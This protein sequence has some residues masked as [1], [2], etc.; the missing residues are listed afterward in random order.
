MFSRPFIL[1]S[2]VDGLISHPASSRQIPLVPAWLSAS[3][4]WC[5][6]DDSYFD[7]GEIEFL[8]SFLVALLWWLKRLNIFFHIVT[9]EL[10]FIW[11]IYLSIFGHLLI[12]LFVLWP[13]IVFFKK[14]FSS[15]CVHMRVYVHTC[16][17]TGAT[18]CLGRPEDSLLELVLFF[19]LTG[20]RDQ[21]QLSLAESVFTRWAILL[22][23]CFSFERVCLI[24]YI[25]SEHNDMK[26]EL[27]SR[28]TTEII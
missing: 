10:Y 20:P 8:F 9:G 12:E 21:S 1:I 19:Y 7:W 16:M 3:L 4:G 28:R 24:S 18:V 6:L 22:A 14:I 17:C 26:Q 27:K 5:F 11:S 25:L 23:H 13:F 15:L 2:A